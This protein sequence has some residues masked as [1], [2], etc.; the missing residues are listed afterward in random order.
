M[1]PRTTQASTSCVAELYDITAV[2][3]I[4]PGTEAP[5]A[6]STGNG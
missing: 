6:V 3:T 2:I 4:Q 5:N 1:L